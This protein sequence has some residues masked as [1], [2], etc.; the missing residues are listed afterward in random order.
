MG[1][2]VILELFEKVALFDPSFR[3]CNIVYD[4]SN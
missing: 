4:R 1:G 2:T 3:V